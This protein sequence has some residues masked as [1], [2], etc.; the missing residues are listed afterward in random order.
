MIFYDMLVNFLV[1]F[2]FGA[3]ASAF[4][5]FQYQTQCLVIFNNIILKVG[6]YIKGRKNKNN[7]LIN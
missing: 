4:L 5:F 6:N 7:N 1:F 2:I 3:I